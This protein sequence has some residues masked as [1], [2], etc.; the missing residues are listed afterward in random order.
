VSKL[1][2]KKMLKELLQASKEKKNKKLVEKAF[3]C[4]LKLHKNQKR[5]SGEP[6]FIHPYQTGLTL[7]KWGLNN[8]TIAAGLLHDII[9]DTKLNE[10]KL[11]QLFGEKICRK[12]QAVTQIK[13]KKLISKKTIKRKS[14]EKT[15]LATINKTDILLIKLADKLHN[16]ETLKFVPKKRQKEIAKTAL[17]VYAPIAQKLGMHSLKFKIENSCFP[18]VYPKENTIIKKF[19]NKNKKNKLK[20]IKKTINI[21]KP[22]LKNLIKFKELYKPNYILFNKTLNKKRNLNELNDF[23]VLIIVV[24]TEKDCYDALRIIHRAF[25]PIPR[26]FKDYIAIPKNN[27]YSAL[28]TTVIGTNKTPLKIYIQTQ[29]MY[30]L[31][32][33][34]VLTLINTNSNKIVKQIDWLKKIKKKHKEVKTD[35][36]LTELLEIDSVDK[37][38]FVFDEKG[39]LINIPQET[40]AIDFFF[41]TNSKKAEY[42][43][44]IIINKK[45]SSFKQPLSAGDIIQGIYSKKP[46]INERWLLL[47]KR[48]ETQKQ[49]KKILNNLKKEQKNQF[50]LLKIKVKN[51]PGVLAIITSKLAENEINIE[52]I[53][54]EKIDR[55][56][57]K[58]MYIHITI[59]GKNSEQIN[60]T[61]N[62]LKQKK[63]I[64]SIKKNK[65]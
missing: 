2:E 11:K 37:N 3:Y 30:E 1:N 61:I 21:L 28:H 65:I 27:I 43:K 53:Y 45:D 20:Q 38:M 44:E 8:E 58:K 46:T 9:E 29:E 19:F 6:Y 22:N 26:K 23:I 13:S 32:K 41:T 62:E 48:K 57:G 50:Y 31:A 24:K 52:E 49:I 18:I 51:T 12:V 5:F 60:K 14:L 39:N 7:A 54:Q 35:K 34:G 4:S 33:K 64:E 63:I 42:L 17:E 15:L 36:Q 10:K 59:K 16:I 40:N 25:K 47:S 56:E 55:L